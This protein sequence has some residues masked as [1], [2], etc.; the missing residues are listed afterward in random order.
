M[1]GYM[2]SENNDNNCTCPHC[3]T[4][5]FRALEAWINGMEDGEPQLCSNCKKTL[6]ENQSSGC[7]DS[8]KK[9]NWNF[10]ISFFIIALLL[11]GLMI[12]LNRTFEVLTF[13]EHSGQIVYEILLILIVSSALASGK[14]LQ[15]LKHL[16]IWAGIFLVLMTGYSYRH[17][18][19]TIKEKVLA[20]IIP[21][22]G[23]RK[24]PDSISF[25]VAANGHFYIRAEV[26][27][28][29][30]IFLADTGASDIVLSPADAGKLG[31]KIDE[32]RFDR[33][34]ETANGT[35]RGS[36]IRIADLRIGK[37]HLKEIGASV[38]E[39]EMKNSLLGMTF[40][41]RLKSYEVKNDVLTLY[42]SE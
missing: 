34:Y 40:F 7:L 11:L 9:S 20:E 39:A 16:A 29:P 4:E 18:L 17:E 13:K 37:I 21:A 22:K 10:N 12:Y 27:G 14:I 41:K 24:T 38:N 3:G 23:F 8:G 6:Y 1:E 15:N 19:S 42:K 33:F 5:N 28:I 36:S 31:I 30:V 32:L 2:Y 26:N 25:P 35:V